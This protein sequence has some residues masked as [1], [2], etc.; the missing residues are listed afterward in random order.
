MGPWIRQWGGVG[1]GVMG[2]QG[3]ESIHAEFNLIE[4]RH[5]NQCHDRAERLRQVMI[6]HLTEPSTARGSSTSNKKAEE[7]SRRVTVKTTCIAVHTTSHTRRVM[8]NKE[9]SLRF[10]VRKKNPK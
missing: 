3:A 2:E 1:F 9:C 4:V 5:R 10:R 8:C 6:E 7:D